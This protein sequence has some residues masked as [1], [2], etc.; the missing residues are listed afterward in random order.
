MGITIATKISRNGLK[1]WYYF[2]W[3]KAADQRKAA[4]MFTWVKPKS[5]TEKNFN[6]ETLSLLDHKL[7][8]LILEK[9]AVG[10]GYIPSHKFKANFLDYYADYVTNNIR[11]GKRHLQIS[12]K[13]FRSF[14]KKDFISPTDITENLCVRFRQYLLDNFNGDT[15]SN[16]FSP[17]KKMV[18]AAT[19]EGYFK[20]NP[21]DEIAAKGNKNKKLKEHLE[22]NEY[23]QLLNTPCYNEE[24]REAFILSCYAGLRWCDV[25]PLD[26][27]DI[28]GDQL[29]TRI[30]QAKTGEPLSVTLHPIA[31]TIL[32]KRKARLSRSIKTG[33]VLN[34]PS[35]D[36]ANKILQ[37]WCNDAGIEKH[38]TWHCARLSF[39]IL[40]QD[41]NVDNATVALLLGHT[42]TK[43]VDQ[44]YKRHRPKDQ[45]GAIQRLPCIQQAYSEV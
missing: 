11:K 7:A 32:E 26:W 12:I 14:I 19:K 22:A 30:I 39:S 16:Y 24:V 42:S 3:G 2:E 45:S 17:F 37:Q 18:K 13:H 40:L 5:Q 35:S 36:G 44:I 6:K 43:Y 34:L 23:I 28:K 9:Q 27:D 31:R 8:Q 29:K 41:A 25:K 10:T 21:V 33:K 4:G 20:H 1:K 15:P 38:I